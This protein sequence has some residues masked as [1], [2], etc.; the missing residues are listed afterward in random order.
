MMARKAQFCCSPFFVCITSCHWTWLSDLNSLYCKAGIASLF[1][2]SIRKPFIPHRNQPRCT[3]YD[4]D[5]TPI[6]LG[7]PYISCFSVIIFSWLIYGLIGLGWDQIT[8]PQIVRIQWAVSSELPAGGR[9]SLV[10][11]KLKMVDLLTL[12]EHSIKNTGLYLYIH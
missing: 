1:C 2:M 5:G 3:L 10:T 11:E 7:S 12:K 6:A 8:Q 4:S 9:I